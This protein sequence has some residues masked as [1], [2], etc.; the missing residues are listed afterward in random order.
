MHCKDRGFSYNAFLILP[1]FVLPFFRNVQEVQLDKHVKLLD[2]PGIVM[3]SGTSDSSI[4]L[5]NCVKVYDVIYLVVPYKNFAFY[6]ALLHCQE[7]SFSQTTACNVF[8]FCSVRTVRSSVATFQLVR[9]LHTT[10]DVVFRLKLF[11][12]LSLQLKLS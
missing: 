8:L 6:E 10:A 4:I 5:R 12:I 9:S 1:L 2:S 3:D 11:M 7:N